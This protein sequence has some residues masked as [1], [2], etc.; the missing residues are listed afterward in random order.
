FN[1]F[2]LTP[3]PVQTT[4]IGGT[5]QNK[6]LKLNKDLVSIELPRG[7]KITNNPSID[8]YIHSFISTP[9]G[10]IIVGSDFSLKMYNSNGLFLKEFSGHTGGVWTLACSADGKYVASGGEDQTVKLWKIDETGYAPGMA[11]YFKGEDDI[12]SL[13]SDLKLDSLS[14]IETRKAWEAAI[15]IIKEN[16]NTKTTRF[17]QEQYD[18]LGETIV[19]FSNFFVSNEGEWVCWAPSGYF[20]CSSSG[21]DSFGWHLNNGVDKLA[22]YYSADQY[23]EILYRPQLLVK[24]FQ[25]VK[26]VENILRDEGEIIFDLSK[27]SRPSAGLFDI[28]DISIGDQK[29]LDYEQGKFFTTTHTIP[30]NVD[31][32]DG[33][34][35]IREV[36]IYQ[37]GKLIVNDLDVKSLQEVK[38]IERAYNVELVNG[39]NNFKLVVVNFQGIE[40]RADL[41]KIE[42]I[43]KEIITS[44]LHIL[45]VGIN[46][47]QK[48][49]YNLNYAQPDASSFAKKFVENGTGLFKN[50]K[51]KIE[52]YD[53][54]AT[55]EN[56]LKAFE[57]IISQSNPEDMFVF[58]YAG[59]G[60]IDEKDNNEY[61]LVPPDITELY[62][63]SKQ[64]K[65]KGISAT[66][67]KQLLY[68][69]KST[70]QLILM[71]ACH[72]GAAVEAFQDKSK[73]SERERAITQLARSSGVAM[74]TSSNSQQ[75]ASEFEVLQHG[76]FTYTL[77]EALS[78]AADTGDEK[79]SVYEL[80]LY[81][82][83][84]VPILSKKYGGESQK[85]IAHVFGNDFSISLVGSKTENGNKN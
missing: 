81:M 76:V 51:N 54:Q 57:L 68:R 73:E 13:F 53:E 63:D 39:T 2:T 77:L 59:H 27:L 69:I 41:L 8:G 3:D 38:Q 37:N 67:L 5:E 31:I 65:D 58:Y 78:G 34:G 56:I 44:S 79:I 83:R 32:F 82:E 72:S 28:N 46:K 55:K 1:E 17:F 74:L 23:F 15:K 16:T 42:Y 49:Q 61:Y 75:F 9:N 24:S 26:R 36:N 47:Y 35:G 62:G 18:N 10:R 14:L 21:A 25:Q 33:G 70:K 64:L 71:D 20:S 22:D 48:E 50:V 30:L 11:S 52:L 45:S 7:K 6:N 4:L 29:I 19:P 85:P 66:E 43:G 84:M 12:M 60:T 40:S 80:K